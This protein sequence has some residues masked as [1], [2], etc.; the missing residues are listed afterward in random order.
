MQNSVRKNNINLEREL[1]DLVSMNRFSSGSS[2]L[3]T[4]KPQSLLSTIKQQKHTTGK[5]GH[6][7]TT[8]LKQSAYKEQEYTL[9]IIENY[10]REVGICAFNFRTMEIFIT[11]FIDNE[12]YVN[13]IT[14]I[15]Y[16]RPLEIVM[17]QRSEGSS[18][19]LMIKSIFLNCY[20]GFCQEKISTKIWG[21]T[22]IQNRP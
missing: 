10:A 17:N 20:V 9:S 11:Q 4:I 6:I 8:A 16:W 3:S 19:H 7:T 21:K 22:S 1:K 5:R 18:L 13:T 15:N 2:L 12:A 14:M